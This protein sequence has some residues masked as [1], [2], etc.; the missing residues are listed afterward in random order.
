MPALLGL[1]CLC[2]MPD[3]LWLIIMPVFF[4]SYACLIM[5][6]LLCLSYNSA[7]MPVFGLSYY[8]CLMPVY[9]ACLMP[10]L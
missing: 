2:L 7:I 3:L 1:F 4:L 5:P 8:A 6:V 9:Y 10:V